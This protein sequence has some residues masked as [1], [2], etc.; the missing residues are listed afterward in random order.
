VTPLMTAGEKATAQREAPA[1]H[2]L[3]TADLGVFIP[4]R[5]VSQL[6]VTCAALLIFEDDPTALLVGVEAFRTDRYV[7]VTD[8]GAK[9]ATR[10]QVRAGRR[11]SP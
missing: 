10:E 9:Y 11:C 6:C 7:I 3:H 2:V 5:L 1:G 4:G 8:D